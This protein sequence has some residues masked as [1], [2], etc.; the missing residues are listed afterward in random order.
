MKHI[1]KVRVFHSEINNLNGVEGDDLG[2]GFAV[3]IEPHPA[4]EDEIWAVT[5]AISNA[6]EGLKL[7]D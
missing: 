5:Q 2:P 3:L 6:L 1:E 7:G 4:S